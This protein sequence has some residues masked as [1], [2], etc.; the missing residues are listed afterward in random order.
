MIFKLVFIKKDLIKKTIEK[1][2]YKSLQ[3]GFGEKKEKRLNK[4]QKDFFTKL[5][6]VMKRGT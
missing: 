5:N 6:T 2:G 1:D 3:L 4:A